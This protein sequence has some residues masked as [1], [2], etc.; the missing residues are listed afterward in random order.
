MKRAVFAIALACLTT[1]ATAQQGA[2]EIEHEGQ[3]LMNQWIAAYNR[4]DANAMAETYAAPDRAALESSFADLRTESFGKL[5]VYAAAFC[6]KDSTHGKA[7]LK[8]ARIYTFG[9]QM[10]GDEAK[11]FDIEKTTAGWRITDETDAS[12]NTVLACS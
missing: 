8:Y 1:P 6:G 3:A 10:N 2:T 9:G 4:G 12:Y 5:D 11:V 7:I